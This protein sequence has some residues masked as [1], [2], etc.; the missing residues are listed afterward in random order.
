[1]GRNNQKQ[2]VYNSN[3]ANDESYWY[4]YNKNGGG[5]SANK[6]GYTHSTNKDKTGFYYNRTALFS[7]GGFYAYQAS[8]MTDDDDNANQYEWHPYGIQD[9]CGVL[10]EDSAKCNSKLK[11][12]DGNDFGSNLSEE[13]L[14]NE[15]TVCNYIGN[16][17]RH[18]YD[19]YGEI[20]LNAYQDAQNTY[21]AI[22]Q[23]DWSSTESINSIREAVSV[24]YWQV[25]LLTLLC[26]GVVGLTITAAVLHAI[27]ARKAPPPLKKTESSTLSYPDIKRDDSGIVLGRSQSADGF[28][29]GK[30]TPLI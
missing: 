24:K 28:V 18:S 27:L 30:T 6:N 11:G 23:I 9:I 12:T 13:Q 16:L 22:T 21:L 5:Y 17:Q 14:Q 25:G 3:N 10:Y 8:K 29:E 4:Q 20:I 19:E 7:D 26:I 15:Q 2:Y 1:M